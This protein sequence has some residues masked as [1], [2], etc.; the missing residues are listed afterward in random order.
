MP[1]PLVT[2]QETLETLESVGTVGDHLVV[3][4][5]D[6]LLASVKRS[7]SYGEGDSVAD[8]GYSKSNSPTG[9]A[10]R[11]S[12]SGCSSMSEREI[13]FEGYGESIDHSDIATPINDADVN[14]AP[15]VIGS[16]TNWMRNS[17][18]RSDYNSPGKRLS[19]SNALASHLYKN[20][21]HNSSSRSSNGD[22]EDFGS[23]AS[24][25][26]D[27]VDLGHKVIDNDNQSR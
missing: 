17:L 3:N 27:V 20:V 12:A 19:G 8:S 9:S 14:P 22:N 6:I 5:E 16:R 4:D 18:R 1:M 26:D 13:S 23:D 7:N 24:L 2:T 15:L 11:G 21:N 25:E 10:P